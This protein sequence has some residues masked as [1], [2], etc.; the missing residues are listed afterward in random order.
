MKTI[1][2]NSMKITLAISLGLLVFTACSQKISD[3]HSAE[4]TSTT[5]VSKNKAPQI[6][7]NM[8]VLSNNLEAVKQHVKVGTD[9]NKKEAMSGSTPLN[10]AASFGK[11][12]IAKVLIEAGADL[13][14]TNND[15]GTALHSAAFFC[16][17]EIVQMLIDAKADK[18][19]KN[20]FG[21]TPRESVMAPFKDMKPIYEMLKLQLEPMG[22]EIDINYIE[23]TRPTIAEMLQ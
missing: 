6:D 12:E 10:T 9:L 3:S 15:G 19:L 13:S 16:R 5:R 7:L 8:A 1:K 21:A 23:E 22:L 11:N 18:S 17:V 2:T 4:T 14:V 20:N